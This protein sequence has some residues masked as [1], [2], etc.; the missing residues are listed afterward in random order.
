MTPSVLVVTARFDA[1]SDRVVTA[2]NSRTT[3]VVRL[4][5]S[6]F[7]QTLTAV[8]VFDG[9][10]WTGSLRTTTRT[11]DLADVTGVYYRRPTDFTFPADMS[12][13]E[14]RWSAQE[15]RLG[16]GGLL[17]AVPNWLNH[18][19]RIAACESSKPLQLRHAAESGLRVP[20]TLVTNDPA[21]ALAFAQGV[22]PVACKPFGSNGVEENGTYR[23]AYAR[24]LDAADL[25]DEPSIADTAHQFQ[26]WIDAAFAVRMTVVDRELF[27]VAIHAGS[28]AARVDWRSDYDALTYE[29]IEPPEQVADGVRVLMDRYGLGFAA[30]DF[31]VD[32]GGS[33]WFLEIGASAQWAWIELVADNIAE[34]I[35]DALTK[36]MR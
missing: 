29:R 26:Q 36:G 28:D 6:E 32:S 10:S 12:D 19:H 16:F 11:L 31:L 33:W 17:A 14:R 4:D 25:L 2:L 20:R 15:A 35:A 8:G 5:L 22:G 23:I 34:A 30:L 7:P 21:A 3:P 24:R 9:T 18:P 1:T 27:T 13:V